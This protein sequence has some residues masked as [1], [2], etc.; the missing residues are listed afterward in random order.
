MKRIAMILFVLGTA[1][2]GWGATYYVDNTVTDTN[3]NVI[4]Q[5]NRLNGALQ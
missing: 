4:N 2:P 1:L 5:Q 3:T